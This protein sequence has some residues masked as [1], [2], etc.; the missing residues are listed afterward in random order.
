M[1]LPWSASSKAQK[2][3]SVQNKNVNIPRN[4]RVIRSRARV[5]RDETQRIA[6]GKPFPVIERMQLGKTAVRRARART[7]AHAHAC[8]S[9]TSRVRFS[10]FAGP[11]NALFPRQS[12][13]NPARSV[14]A[15]PTPP[16]PGNRATPNNCVTKPKR[17]VD[18]ALRPRPTPPPPQPFR[19][20][21]S[22]D[23][24]VVRHGGYAE[25]IHKTF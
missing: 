8:R 23:G 9:T 22:C 5:G 20:F 6:S 10:G 17:Y 16:R 11:L 13:S 25:K 15:R 4:V 12:S 1:H 7:Y 24:R 18:F 3:K 21:E 2:P 19:V 14:A